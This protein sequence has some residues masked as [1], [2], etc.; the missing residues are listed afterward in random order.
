MDRLLGRFHDAGDDPEQMVETMFRFGGYIGEVIAR[1]AGGSWVTVTEDHPMGGGW[2]M[3]D[4][5]K[6]E[7]V[8]NPIGKAFKRV[9]NGG[10]D[11][12][13]YFYQAVVRS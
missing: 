1:E 11:S 6:G 4:L 5:A 8:V 7:H 3:I 12:I 2:P 9:R 10:V 13:V